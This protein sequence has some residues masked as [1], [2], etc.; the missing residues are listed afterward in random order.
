[1]REDPFIVKCK[2]YVRKFK[3]KYCVPEPSSAYFKKKALH[4]ALKYAQ[5]CVIAQ[6]RKL[7]HPK[8]PL[9]FIHGGAGSRKSTLLSSLSQNIHNILKKEGDDPDC[10]Y[11]VLSSYT[12]T[13]AA[14]IGDIKTLLKL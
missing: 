7:P 8:A 3:S 13:A 6:K 5:N 10:P 14:N 1:M 2:Q 11:I 12:G 4:I 9:L